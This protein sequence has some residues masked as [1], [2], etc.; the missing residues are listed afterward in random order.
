MVARFICNPY[1]YPLAVASKMQ[2]QY[3]SI[4]GKI[5][6][7]TARARLRDSG[8]RS[9]GPRIAVL[10]ALSASHG[11]LSH[12]ELVFRLGRHDMDQATVYRNLLKLEEFGLTR[13]AS[14]VGGV[15]RYEPTELD[16]KVR[17]KHP[18]FSCKECGIVT[19]M[20]PITFTSEQ[21]T[22]WSFA[23]DMAELSFVGVCPECT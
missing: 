3:T 21:E 20:S 19:C 10:Q 17:Q 14:Q 13:I 7:E 2:A 15:V 5:S 23:L 11:P 12:G 16:G 22:S 4:V 9:T 8:L 6:K 18:H 1:V